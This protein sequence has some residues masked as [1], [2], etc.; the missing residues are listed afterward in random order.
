MLKKLGSDDGATAY[1]PDACFYVV[2]YNSA[3]YKGARASWMIANEIG[4]ILQAL[5]GKRVYTR[6]SR[7]A[8]KIRKTKNVKMSGVRKPRHI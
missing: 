3:S 8:Y 7:A 2:F 4:H 1:F 5:R 6:A